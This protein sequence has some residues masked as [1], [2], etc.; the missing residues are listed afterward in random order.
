MI[1]LKDN[2]WKTKN[3]NEHV[4]VFNLVYFMFL[5]VLFWNKRK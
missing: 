4:D 5:D 2:T 1:Y 3:Y